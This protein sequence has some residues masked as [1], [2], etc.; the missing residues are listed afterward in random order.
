MPLWAVRIRAFLTD[1]PYPK[2]GERN[3]CS[4]TQD[5]VG[6]VYA[7][8]SVPWEDNWEGTHAKTSTSAYRKESL[9]FMATCSCPIMPVPCTSSFVYWEGAGITHVTQPRRTSLML[10]AQNSL[11]KTCRSNGADWKTGV[12]LQPAL[13]CFKKCWKFPVTNLNCSSKGNIF[14]LIYNSSFLFQQEV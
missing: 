11:H 1:I 4:L 5:M 3:P 12:I 14:S 8:L 13:P 7:A 6:G 10:A 9:E 2:E